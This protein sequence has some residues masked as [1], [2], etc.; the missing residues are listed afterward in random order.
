ML[1]I[2]IKHKE[3]ENFPIIKD[4]NL[5]VKTSEF[6]SIIGP[7]GCGKTTLLNI[8]SN[9]DKKY[10]GHIKLDSKDQISS[11]IGFMFQDSRLIPWLS[12]FENIMLVSLNKNVDDIIQAL[13]NIGLRDYI[14]S[15]PKELSGGMQRRVALVRAFINKP[16][17]ILLDEPFI[18]LD[19]PSAQA[20]RKDFLTMCKEYLP[21]VIL[22]THD[23]EEAI[24][25]SKRIIFLDSKPMKI[26]LD[27]KNNSDF[28]NNLNHEDIQNIKAELLDENPF[29][30]S[31]KLKENPASNLFSIIN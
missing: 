5:Q 6:I 13:S 17:L 4:F 24:S 11:N 30:L 3:F 2:N 19:H 12:V 14:N 26:V 15:Y 10:H 29:I 28:S 20:L 7:S 25:L 21:T 23:L 1:D 8:I 22:V 27:Y 16:K 18:S 9:L 31:G